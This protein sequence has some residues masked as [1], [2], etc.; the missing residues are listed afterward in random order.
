MA[1]KWPPKTPTHT[2]G[3][4][5]VNFTLFGAIQTLK[6]PWGSKTA[7]EHQTFDGSLTFWPATRSKKDKMEIFNPPWNRHLAV[8][9]MGPKKI[10][11]HPFKPKLWWLKV[12]SIKKRPKFQKIHSKTP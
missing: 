10:I 4:Y 7:I 2:V 9:V 5:S 11:F 1:P 8:L 6:G 3:L 12:K